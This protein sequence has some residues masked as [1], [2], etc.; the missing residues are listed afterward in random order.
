MDNFQLDVNDRLEV[1]AKD[2]AYKSLIT[3][4]DDDWI[5]I[6]VPVFEGEYLVLYSGEMVIINMYLDSGK[7]Y[8]FNAKVL[9]KGKEGNIPYYK[10]SEPINIKRIQRRNYF[11]VGI[12]NNA[13]YKNITNVD[14][15]DIDDKEYI[16]AMMLDLSGGGL[17][18]KINED[19]HMHDILSI[20]MRIKGSEII[21]NGEVVRIEVSEDRN[22]M[23]GIKFL[24]ISQSQTDRIIEE[25]FEIMRK[26]RALT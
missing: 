26:Q 5:K 17:K 3:D 21:V 6:N 18:L 13:Y 14:K 12:L 24:D 22:K 25:L 11:R 16:E 8:S 2:K 1:I 23:C 4:F 19:V 10:L 20:K 9:S 7:C 15:N